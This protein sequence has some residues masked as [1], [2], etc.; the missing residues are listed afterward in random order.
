VLNRFAWK[1]NERERNGQSK[2]YGSAHRGGWNLLIQ[3]VPR[4]EWEAQGKRNNQ[5]KKKDSNK[6]RKT[7]WETK[8]RA[9]RYNNRHEKMK[10]VRGRNMLEKGNPKTRVLQELL[11]SS[12][13][14]KKTNT[15][16]HKR[17]RRN[18]EDSSENCIKK[19]GVPGQIESSKRRGFTKEHE[20]G[21]GV[22]GGKYFV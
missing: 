2:H 12:W 4:Q 15:I 19:P 18:R 11:V 17:S 8:E 20:A 6:K 21:N 16:L 5:K 1:K 14:K 7:M 22:S 3:T 9:Q 10:R 13:R